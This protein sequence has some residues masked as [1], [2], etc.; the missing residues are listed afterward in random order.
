MSIVGV[1]ASSDQMFMAARVPA[2]GF[3]RHRLNERYRKPR[4]C[5][6]TTHSQV[7]LKMGTEVSTALN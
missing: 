3:A 5:E 2:D 1:L 4:R 7:A 6:S